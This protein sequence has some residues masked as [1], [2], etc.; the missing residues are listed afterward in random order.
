MSR[1]GTSAVDIVAQS[2]KQKPAKNFHAIV[3]PKYLD[4]GGGGGGSFCLLSKNGVVPSPPLVY[5]VKQ[6]PGRIAEPY[7]TGQ[8]FRHRSQLLSIIGH[9]YL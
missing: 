2:C 9:Y 8:S 1:E 3:S 4:S 5:S 6:F 7:L